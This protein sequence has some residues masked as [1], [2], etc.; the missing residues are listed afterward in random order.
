MF[1]KEPRGR[2]G[3]AAPLASPKDIA[4]RV[5]TVIASLPSLQA[6]LAVATGQAA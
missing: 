6:S 2:A 3:G 1:D 4:D 5:E